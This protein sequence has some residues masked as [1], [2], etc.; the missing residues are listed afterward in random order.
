MLIRRAASD[1]RGET[2]ELSAASRDEAAAV[3]RDA[4]IA[5][6]RATDA[7]DS[8]DSVV[9]GLMARIENGALPQL[10]PDLGTQLDARF[11]AI[12]RN[13]TLD[14]IQSV[15]ASIANELRSEATAARKAAD[16]AAQTIISLA[17]QFRE[18]WKGASADLV[19]SVEG[20]HGFIEL[21]DTIVANGLPEHEARFFELLRERSR[22]MIAQIVDEIMHAP[23]E[24]EA[25]IEPVNASLAKSPFDEGRFLKIEVKTKRGEAATEFLQDLRSIS[26]HSWMEGGNPADA[27]SRF[28]KLA[29]I[30]HRLDSSDAGDRKWR[31]LCLDTRLHVT[32][33]AHEVD[34]HGRVHAT[35]DSGASMSGGQQQKLVV[36]CLAAAL[37]YQLADA[38]ELLPRYGTIVL[39]EAF[40]KTDNRYTR[41]ALDVFKE[42]GFQLV[43]ATPHKLLRTIEPYVGGVTEVENPSRARTQISN[44]IWDDGRGGG[45]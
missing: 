43:L 16:K 8:R 12:R 45:S 6:T 37:R 40:D 28:A 26:E 33:L 15:A 31:E 22:D 38:D 13:I 42:F 18:R 34:E 41:L 24:I 32:F 23:A 19:A 1:T 27:E 20:R 2:Y 14:S 35:Y 11:A 21:Y 36:F 30:M 44:L 5:V 4:T 39:D 9:A 17:T 25:R 10:D 3:T 7:R 29:G